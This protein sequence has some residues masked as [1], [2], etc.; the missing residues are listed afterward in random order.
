MK[1]KIDINEV[2]CRCGYFM[3]QLPN[4]E[5][6]CS[7][8]GKKKNSYQSDINRRVYCRQCGNNMERHQMKHEHWGCV[9]CGCKSETPLIEVKYWEQAVECRKHALVIK[10]IDAYIHQVKAPLRI[11]QESIY[12]D[13]ER[14]GID[15]WWSE[16]SDYIIKH[17][18]DI[19]MDQMLKYFKLKIKLK[20]MPDELRS[21]IHGAVNII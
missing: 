16:V 9:H 8:C 6:E 20:P 3:L 13:V 11:H 21:R 19:K 18:C 4:G 5:Y 14:W 2:R 15:T 10:I 1:D 7:D 17:G 12:R